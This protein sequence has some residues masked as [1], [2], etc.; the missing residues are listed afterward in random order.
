MS[1][2]SEDDFDGVLRVLRQV[3]D[4]GR[5]VASGYENRVPGTFRGLAVHYRTN[6]CLATRE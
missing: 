1:L 6:D 5:C 2:V 3:V 4:D